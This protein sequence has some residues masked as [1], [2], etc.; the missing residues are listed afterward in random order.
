MYVSMIEHLVTLKCAGA[1]RIWHELLPE[2]NSPR[3]RQSIAVS[4]FR[5]WGMRRPERDALTCCE[6]NTICSV[7]ALFS[8]VV[9]AGIVLQL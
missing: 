9:S 2:G 6:G 1:A 4:G 3:V 8:P 7:G 5:V